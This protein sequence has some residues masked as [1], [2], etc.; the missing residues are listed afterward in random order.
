MLVGVIVA[1]DVVL[2]NRTLH[3]CYR[4][5]GQ[6]PLCNTEMPQSQLQDHVEE[7]LMRLET[8]E[9]GEQKEVGRLTRH[10]VQAGT[11]KPAETLTQG[12]SRAS[13]TR[14]VIAV[15]SG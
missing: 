7:C 5:M 4:K 2:F 8:G 15:D 10:S 9:P 1:Q 3:P 12:P 6:C 13:P 11:K 14:Q